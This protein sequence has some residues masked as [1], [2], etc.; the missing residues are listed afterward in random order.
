MLY[1]TTFDGH[2][3]SASPLGAAPPACYAARVRWT[4][5]PYRADDLTSV[6]AV[7]RAS[8]HALG[9]PAYDAAQRAAWAPEA[10]DTEAWARR[11]GALEVLVADAD[12]G[13]RGFV[14]WTADGYLDL[15]YVAP[16][17]ARQGVATALYAEVEASLRAAGV[18]GI[19]TDASDIARPFFARQGFVWIRTNRVERR[20]ETLRN[21]RMRKPLVAEP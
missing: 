5:R 10:L 17:A 16:D 19:E 15:L 11:L 6:L 4:V 1:N 12:P 9:A 3:G 8:V 14:A 13:L 7:F 21:H 20:G 18:E 2:F